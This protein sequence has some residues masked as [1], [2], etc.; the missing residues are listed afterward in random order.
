MTTLRACLVVISGWT[1][2]GLALM[3]AGRTVRW[4]ITRDLQDWRLGDVWTGLAVSVGGVFAFHLVLPVGPVVWLGL[5][6]LAVAGLVLGPRPSRRHGTS[7]TV[8]ITFTVI[9]SVSALY[10]ADRALLPASAYDSGLYHLATLEWM[11]EFRAVPGLANFQGLLAYNSGSSAFGALV[12]STVPS[13]VSHHF[14]N[15]LLFVLIVLEILRAVFTLLTAELGRARYFGPILL[16]LCTPALI[17]PLHR[18]QDISSPSPDLPALVVSLAA[19]VYVARVTAAEADSGDWITAVSLLALMPVMR[20]QLAIFSLL[21]LTF[22]TWWGARSSMPLRSRGVASGLGGLLVAVWLPWIIH[23]YVL[24]GY[25]AYP[26]TLLGLPVAWQASPAQMAWITDSLR[27][28]S[29]DPARPP[30]AVLANWDWLDGWSAR[31]VDNT[32]ILGMMLL[33][34][35]GFVIMLGV[36]IPASWSRARLGKP[37]IAVCLGGMWLAL[38]SVVVK[39]DS[40]PGLIL[41]GFAALLVA[42]LLGSI[43]ATSRQSGEETPWRIPA[44]VLGVAGV[45]TIGA[46][47]FLAPNPR[48]LTGVLWVT[49]AV[50]AASALSVLAPRHRKFTL[51]L[52]V[53]VLAAAMAYPARGLQQEQD[54]APTLADPAWPWGLSE[55]ATAPTVTFERDGVTFRRPTL[56]DQCWAD[57]L[58]CTPYTRHWRLREPGHLGAGFIDT[59]R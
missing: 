34:V 53:L 14:T 10:I 55:P 56:T 1:V 16:V 32:E 43:V 11:H 59:R 35:S 28:W 19:A 4:L 44:L 29:R 27:A 26:S 41:L 33:I 23:G 57:S 24:S 50:L 15:S 58:P 38:A 18:P 42:S 25:P 30:E 52:G 40:H 20:V 37:G 17:Y 13:G 31:T 45:T 39:A 46:W 36:L 5:A 48:F 47:F 21:A 6:P 54:F 12:G 7:P 3:G 9:A 2:L 51:L 49:A 8:L 22:L